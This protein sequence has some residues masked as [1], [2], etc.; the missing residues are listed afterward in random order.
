MAKTLGI[1]GKKVGMTRIFGPGGKAIPVTVIEAGPCP[2][3]QKKDKDRDGYS[4][5]QVGFDEV[6]AKKLTK[7]N[8]EHQKKAG[9]GFYRKLQEFRVDDVA[10]YELGQDLKVD[11][12]KPGERV[13]VTARSK[14]RGFAGVIKRWN[15]KGSPASH[16]H[17]KVHR[18]PGAIGQC[19]DPARVFKGKKM[20]GQMGNK[21]VTRNNTEIVD[22]RPEDNIIL[23]RGQVPGPNGG[24]II[25]CKKS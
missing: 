22:I 3:I 14:G 9:S 19:A 17:E 7:P 16:G 11:I 5:L 4:A 2:V 18:K 12:F 1:I 13:N 8:R 24:I 6:P 23:V 15:F 21:N 25:V 10:G 20:P